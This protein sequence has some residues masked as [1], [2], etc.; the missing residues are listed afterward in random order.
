MPIWWRVFFYGLKLRAS[1][2]LYASNDSNS[3]ELLKGWCINPTIAPFF[4]KE[5]QI[6][7]SLWDVPPTF[8]TLKISAK[9][10][11][12]NEI[13][14][15]LWNYNAVDCCILR[16]LGSEAKHWAF[17][18][19]LPSLS[20][21]LLVLASWIIARLCMYYKVIMTFESWLKTESEITTELMFCAYPFKLH[22]EVHRD[23]LPM[24]WN[25]EVIF[26]ST[27]FQVCLICLVDPVS[28]E[29][30]VPYFGFLIFP[31]HLGGGFQFCWGAIHGGCGKAA[32]FLVARGGI[33]TVRNCTWDGL[34]NKLFWYV[35]V[36]FLCLA[37]VHLV[38]VS[39]FAGRF[40]ETWDVLKGFLTMYLRST[41]G[42]TSVYS[43]Y[44]HLDI[45]MI[46]T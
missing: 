25:D 5:V 34:G 38:F 28:M 32:Q 10:Q 29:F 41:K 33:I 35:L 9:S 24:Y 42:Q 8:L 31:T 23:N 16:F 17:M 37:M 11:D 39:F 30:W 15:V 14:P 18:S 6:V 7:S 22:L 46:L 43:N 40:D 2:F 19:C 21:C 26:S 12:I 45:D 20:M 3:L 44:K 4:A 27:W 36:L 13:N 1:T